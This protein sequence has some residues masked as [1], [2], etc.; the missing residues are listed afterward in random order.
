V[1]NL[2]PNKMLSPPWVHFC[3][4][5]T[6]VHLRGHLTWRKFTNTVFLFYDMYLR[7]IHCYL[8]CKLKFEHWNSFPK[9]LALSTWSTAGAP[10]GP[11]SAWAGINRLFLEYKIANTTFWVLYHIIRTP[12]LTCFTEHSHF[13]EASQEKPSAFL[14][15]QYLI[16]RLAS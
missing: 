6:S 1:S 5:L 11:L 4:P 9:A 15:N 12:K 10:R 8:L 13:W 2:M 7:T 3:F 16:T 14:W